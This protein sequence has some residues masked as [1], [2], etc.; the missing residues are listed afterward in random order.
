MNPETKELLEKLEMYK[1]NMAKVLAFVTDTSPMAAMKTGTPL[2]MREHAFISI[3]LAQLAEIET[4]RIV[5][6]TRKLVWLTW[7]LV[8]V[9]VALLAFAIWQTVIIKEDAKANRQHLQA[10]QYQQATNNI[11]PKS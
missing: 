11:S 2:I 9:S 1:K 10:G 7:G 5:A 8:A 6:M 3:T 4:R